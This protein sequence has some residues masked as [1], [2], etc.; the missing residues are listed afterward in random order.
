M[1]L[2]TDESYCTVAFADTWHANRGAL[3]WTTLTTTEKEQALRRA[4]DYIEQAYRLVWKGYKTSADQILSFPRTGVTRVGGIGYYSSSTVPTELQSACAE[5]AYKAAQGDLNPDL[6]SRVV[7]EK[8]DVVEVEY[9]KN[10][11]QYT[12]YRAIDLILAPL[13]ANSPNGISRGLV[14]A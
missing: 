12:R 7:R 8:I 3:P 10:T 14:R 1:S 2:T 4:T 13:M 6:S 5:L 11:P 9:D